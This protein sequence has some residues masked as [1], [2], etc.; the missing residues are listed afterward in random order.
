MV[1]FKS[2]SYKNFLSTGDV[3][4]CINLDA[5]DKTLI[6]GKNGDGKSQVL[7]A[8]SFVLFGKPHRKITIPQ[9]VNS[10]NNK[11]TVVTIEFEIGPVAYKIVRGIKPKIFEIYQN[12]ELVNQESHARDYQ[13]LLETN[14]L[15]L[16]HK[17]FHQVVVLGSGNFV[18][19]MELAAYHRR[20]VIEDLLDIGMF[21]KMNNIN[22]E[23]QSKLKDLIKDTDHHLNLVIEK[24]RLSTKHLN[25][26]KSIDAKNSKIYQDEIDELRKAISDLD[27]TNTGLLTQYDSQFS[28]IK[29]E[30]DKKQ[31]AL[32]KLTKFEHSIK[33]NIS[34]VVEDAKFYELNDH[35]PT[36]SQ[37][38]S[39]ETKDA[40]LHVCKSKAGELQTGFE[41]IK[42]S[43]NDAALA[44]NESLN[45]LNEISTLPNKVSSNNTIIHSHNNRINALEK[46]LN[47]T[48]ETS[49]I[50]KSNDLLEKLRGERTILTELKDKQV[51]DR[52]Y[53]EVIAEL[54]KDTGIKT[55]IIKQYLPVMNKLINQYLQ[56]LDFFVSFHLDE[57]FNETIRSRHRDDFTFA[58]F[59]EGE[60]SKISL[61]LLFAWRQIAKM[62]NTA[63][64]NLLILDE[65]FDGSL[66]SASTEMLMNILS[67]LDVGTRV[68]V[69]SH[70][71]D[72]HESHFD[73][74]LEAKKVN[75]FSK[76][77]EN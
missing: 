74:V 63:S 39:A 36:C 20:E 6:I 76:L 33:F 24:I 50:T 67:T 60:K 30:L 54:L 42:S 38:I 62:K 69:I 51:E 49:D 18:P 66:D 61:A 10:I 14:I 44:F 17:S 48:V 68:F 19:F 34:K 47:A 37:A 1:I 7:D 45:R 9:L 41:Q 12:G 4:I 43:I 65:V 13:K 40:K 46:Q 15:K 71:Q 27:E 77:I 52:A 2:I 11:K 64:T 31:S 73:R 25:D 35:C 22:K 59:S 26:L 16:N 32:D 23:D 29:S 55:K 28:K 56:V 3:P 72:T 5:C 70:K 75:N 58:S 57:S 21:T 53:N 8:L